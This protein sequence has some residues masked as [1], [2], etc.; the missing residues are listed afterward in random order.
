MRGGF[1]YGELFLVATFVLLGFYLWWCQ[2]AARNR[3]SE[4][5]KL[6]DD[7]LASAKTVN[8]ELIERTEKQSNKL[9]EEV[10]AIRSVLEKR[11]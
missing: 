4:T 1:G 3:M 7:Y 8:N 10:R 11:N 9:L 2:I 6:Y 5:K